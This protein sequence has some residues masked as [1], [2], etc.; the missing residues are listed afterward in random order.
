[1]RVKIAEGRQLRD[2]VHKRL[3]NAG[4]V[5][6]V[7]DS[8]LYWRRRVRDGDVTVEPAVASPPPRP[9]ARTPAP[10]THARQH[11]EH[12]PEG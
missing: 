6:E 4:D 12:K 9:P 11:P 10:A 8:D 7:R 1:M 3:Y 5:I 2:P